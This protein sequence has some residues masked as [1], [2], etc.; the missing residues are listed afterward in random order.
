MA[1]AALVPTLVVL[2][3]DNYQG[4]QQAKALGWLG[5][6]PA[7]GIVLAFLL[8]G[9]LTGWVGW[10]AMFGLL[11]ALALALLQFSNK[12]S[13][14][15]K[16]SH[17]D[18]DWVGAALAGV[19]V[20]LISLGTSNLVSWGT[21][22]ARPDAPFSVL[23]SVARAADGSDRRVSTAGVHLMVATAARSGTGFAGRAGSRRR[24]LRACRPALDFHRERARF[25]D[26]ISDPALHSSRARPRQLRDRAER[27]SVLDGELHRGGDGDSFEEPPQSRAHRPLLVSV[28]HASAWRCSARPYATT[29]ATPW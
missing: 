26:H 23:D 28:G 27:D 29:G 17:V 19:G 22:L 6:A 24:H 7:M 2:V 10:R 3:A 11:A 5:G 16:P 4:H 21:L 15:R 12:L 14:E 13:A 18:I 1:A 25:G 20:I 8:A 9:S